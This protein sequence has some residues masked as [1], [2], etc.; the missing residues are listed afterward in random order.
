VINQAITIIHYYRTWFTICLF[1]ISGIQH[2]F[3]S[4]IIN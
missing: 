2:H 4:D 3:L 1:Q